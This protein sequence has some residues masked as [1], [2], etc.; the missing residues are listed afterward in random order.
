MSSQTLVHAD[1]FFFI[2]TICFSLLTLFI[3][4]I[5]VYIIG[6][7]RRVKRITEKI[8]SGMSAVQEDTKE[9]IADLQ[10]S[11]A[12]RMIF[13]SKGRGGKSQDAKKEKSK[14]K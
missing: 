7:M 12:F 4:I 1:I 11:T 13:G 8:E 2:A 3:L 14:K 10:D 5:L 6:I 9:F